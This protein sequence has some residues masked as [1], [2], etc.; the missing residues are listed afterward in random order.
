M[1]IFVNLGASLRPG[2]MSEETRALLERMGEVR[3]C[4]ADPLSGEA[5]RAELSGADLLITGWGQRTLHCE[6]IGDVKL[7][8][9]TGGTV[10]GIV[11]ED[12]FEKGITVLSGN[13]YYAESVAEGVIAYMLFAL[14][15]M[16]RY[17]AETKAGG[18]PENR[19]RGLLGKKVGIVS[20]GAISRLVIGHLRHFGCE[21]LAYSTRPDPAYAAAAGIRYATLEEIFSECDIVS[22]HT[23]RTPA[24][25][26]MI[27]ARL[28]SLLRPGA[29]FLNTARGEV[30][31]EKDLLDALSTGRFSAV[32]D[33]Y[34][35]EPLP[36]DHPFH[37]LP[38]VTLFPHQC[39]PT[40]DR[41]DYI[42]RELLADATR[43]FAGEAPQNAITRDIAAH[44]T[45]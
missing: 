8:L 7:I 4:P 45:H 14:R 2:F 1:R 30:V 5:L 42:T 37:T 24:T 41:R 13:R 34:N 11:G 35:T 25:I 21:V 32:L 6:D 39:G 40:Y 9:H 22:L 12:I 16:G 31:C 10:G 20:V 33:V 38:N 23:A 3:Y 36:P 26:G 44:M 17:T 19:T 27:D 29:L 15:D 28:L 43:F 18:W